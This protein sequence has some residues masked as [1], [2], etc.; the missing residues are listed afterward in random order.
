[1]RMFR[2]LLAVAVVISAVS[3]AGCN[4]RTCGLKRQG[5]ET[6]ESTLIDGIKYDA[7]HRI[8][9]VVLDSGEIY[10][11]QKVPASVYEALMASDS[12]GQYFTSQIKEKYKYTKR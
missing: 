2:C 8:L 11:Y 7:T 5:F 1:M 10:D 9:S 3:L 4:T 12:K 6:V